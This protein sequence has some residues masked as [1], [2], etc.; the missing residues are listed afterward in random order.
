M[1]SMFKRRPTV[2]C[3]CYSWSW[4]LTLQ[5]EEAIEADSEFCGYY[6]P[7]LHAC[8]AM[9]NIGARML[10]GRI[11]VSIHPSPTPH[12]PWLGARLPNSGANTRWLYRP[13]CCQVPAVGARHLCSRACTHHRQPNLDLQRG[14]A[15]KARSFSLK[16]ADPIASVWCG[17]GGL[18]PHQRF[19]VRKLIADSQPPVVCVCLSPAT[20]DCYCV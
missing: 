9:K 2:G 5:L 18:K 8:L 19:M 10:K 13:S 16:R 3:I 6:V 12:I 1:H 4:E 11:F 14:G 17:I 20:A 7:L 15:S